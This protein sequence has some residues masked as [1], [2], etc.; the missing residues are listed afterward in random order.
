MQTVLWMV[1]DFWECQ[2]VGSGSCKPCRPRIPV[3]TEDAFEMPSP[4]FFAELQTTSKL[5][6]DEFF[7]KCGVKDLAD[8]PGTTSR[9]LNNHTA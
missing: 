1:W 5:T 2:L 4:A 9:E 8:I 6:D 3:I 7:A